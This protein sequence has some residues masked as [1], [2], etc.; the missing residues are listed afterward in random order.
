[1]ATEGVTHRVCRGSVAV[2]RLDLLRQL[3]HRQWGER[4]NFLPSYG[5]FA[6]GCRLAAARDEIAVH[7]LS[8]G[9]TVIAIMVAFEVAQR[10][11][12]YQSARLTDKRWREAST[13]LIAEAISDAC[14][15]GFNEVD[16]LRGD[17]GYKRNFAPERRQVLRLRA[18]AGWLG[19]CAMTTDM[20]ASSAKAFA[21]QA[22]R[23]HRRTQR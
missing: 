15:R 11:S 16:F 14:R 13:V 5:R 1:L 17:E 3:H 21:A 19:R 20:A 23:R 7:E 18:A 10:V 12:L 22:A 9:E 6:E 8:A 2:E 4:S